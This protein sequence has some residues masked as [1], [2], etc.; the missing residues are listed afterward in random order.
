MHIFLC[1]MVF[2]NIDYKVLSDYLNMHYVNIK[3]SASTIHFSLLPIHCEVQ[4]E[5]VEFRPFMDL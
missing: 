5:I 3:L 4:V 1:L 2:V